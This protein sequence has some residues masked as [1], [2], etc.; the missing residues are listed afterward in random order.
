MRDKLAQLPFEEK[1]RKVGELIQLSRK[2]K[3]QRDREDARNYPQSA[4]ARTAI[5]EFKEMKSETLHRLAQLPFEEHETKRE[6]S[7]R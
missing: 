2:I 5:E 7:G 4:I 3:A 1:I 6:R